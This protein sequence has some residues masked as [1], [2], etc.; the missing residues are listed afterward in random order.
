MRANMMSYRD[1]SVY[2]FGEVNLL[3]L[4]VEDCLGLGK[5]D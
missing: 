4:P 3:T 2:Y 5:E 1:F